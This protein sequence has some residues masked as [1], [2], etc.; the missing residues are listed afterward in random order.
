[1]T[2]TNPSV[3]GGQPT[4][5]TVD[6]PAAGAQPQGDLRTA[7]SGMD[8]EAMA[9][10]MDS[11]EAGDT[12]TLPQPEVTPPTP[13]TP[14]AGEQPAEETPPEPVTPP[15][16][17]PPTEPQEPTTP[18]GPP[19]RLSTRALEDA[20]KRKLAD[21]LDLV[22]QGQA[23]D[24]AT[25]I[26]QLTPQA[27]PAAPAETTPAAPPTP[28][29][30]TEAPPEIAEI[31]SK[32]ASL[33]EQRTKAN[34]E[35]LAPEV[36]RL[37]NEIEELN[38]DLIRSESAARELQSRRQSYQSGYFAAVDAVEAM[39]PELNEE[40]EVFN[41]DFSEML[42][43]RIE[44][45]KS[46]RDPALAD[47]NFIVAFAEKTAKALGIQKATDTKPAPR[48]PAPPKPTV[49]KPP[50]GS[51]VAPGHTPAARPTADQIQSLI[52]EAPLEALLAVAEG[53]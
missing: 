2:D 48:I 22:R 26:L 29:Q 11:L 10:I 37:T 25:A 5:Q 32:I 27:E 20:D 36:D 7:I 21:A 51:S 46:R 35:Y 28:V 53:F 18:K 31:K 52:K 39:Y 23:P 50:V 30:Q 15:E 12:V 8:A 34:E 40:S 38:L 45:A 42:T 44:A 14:P 6:T 16:E 47:P 24:I 13:T 33:R 4:P 19:N 43:D 1:M 17:V 41:P 49:V 3:P 9:S